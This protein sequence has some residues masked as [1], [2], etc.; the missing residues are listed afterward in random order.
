M[1]TFRSQKMK[2]GG[3]RMRG[4]APRR[5]ELRKKGRVCRRKVLRASLTVECAAVLPLFVI[6]MLT[7]IV[8]MDA[9]R[10]ETA[11]NLQLSNK[12]RKLASAA[13]AAGE[14]TGDLWIDLGRTEKLAF[15][16]PTF[17]IAPVK[18]AVR[19]R[20]YPF[21]GSDKGIGGMYDGGS[22]EDS[23]LVYV[24]DN[25]EVYHTHGDCSHLDLT[26]IKTDKAGV[27]YLRNVDGQL[28]RRCRGFPGG[29]E[30]TVYVTATGRYFYP[31]TD[32]N[33]LTRHVH[34]VKH[35]EYKGLKQCKR[36]A[37]RDAKDARRAS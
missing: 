14:K 37:A 10:L 20:V 6:A 21:V 19:A 13:G 32:Y 33:S 22:G 24:T 2:K 4:T 11:K 1:R 15:P 31:S 3:Q 25:G 17:G 8:F 35:S 29:Y 27:Q 23:G 36:C 5:A 30:G 28:Y 26:I 16:F 18:V 7:L 9:V 34:I 12:A